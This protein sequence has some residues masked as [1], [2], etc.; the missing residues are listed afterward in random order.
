MDV[1]VMSHCHA[2]LPFFNNDVHEILHLEISSLILQRDRSASY[3][4][5]SLKAFAAPQQTLTAIDR[6]TRLL[7]RN[8]N[9]AKISTSAA[10]LN[11]RN[12]TISKPRARGQLTVG[13]AHSSYLQQ[14]KHA[15]RMHDC[16]LESSA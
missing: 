6:P 2:N 12:F 3:E 16:H 8:R 7:K 13:Q 14:I 11:E 9:E 5:N 10:K 1:L 4:R 15:A